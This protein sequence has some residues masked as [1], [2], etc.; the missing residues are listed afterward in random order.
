M[1]DP[2]LPEHLPQWV[3]GDLTLDSD[4]LGWKGMRLRGYRYGPLDVPVPPMR[5]YMIVVYGRGAT[6]MARQCDSAWRDEYVH[7]GSVSLLTHQVQSHWRWTHGID[8]THF[9]LSPDQLAKVGCAMFD[10]EVDNVELMDVLKADDPCLAHMVREL[11][12]EV[13]GPGL[14]GRLYADAIMNQAC[15][16]ILRNYANVVFKAQESRGHF[17]CYQKR[18]LLE[19]IH[20]NL[21][22]NILLADLA[23]VAGLSLYC[24]ARRFRE[25]FGMPP[26]EYVLNERLEFAKSLLVN[27]KRPLKDIA[28]QSGFSDQSHM[29]RVFRSRA[30]VTPGQFR[31]LQ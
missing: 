18:Q 29:T 31:E 12:A 22:A 1:T 13:H 2:I 15:V 25:T 7:P 8:V 17:S 6:P 30:Q 14:G 5:D 9:Y 16:H 4:S 19:Y 3:P 24:F 26:H 10:R 28:V 21:D 20:A 27:S 11:A 23:K